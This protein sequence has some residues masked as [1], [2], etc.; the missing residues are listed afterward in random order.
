MIAGTL[1]VQMLA[2]IARLRQDMQE[3]K[4]TVSKAVGDINRV[5]GSIGMGIS[6]GVVAAGFAT[7]IR[8]A[9]D[10]AISQRKLDAIIRATGN[11]SG[12]TAD[13][14][15]RLADS[16]ARS[17]TFDDEAFRE[18]TATLLRFGNIGGANL[19]KV[20][21]LSA[22]YAALTGGDLVSSA[23]KMGRAL[24]NPAEGLSKLERHF[25]S[26]APEVEAAIKQQAKMGDT[27][28]ALSIAIEA[29]Q[30]KIGGAD[31]Q[32]NSGLTGSVKQLTKA[33]SELMEVGGQ[34]GNNSAVTGFL[35]GLSSRLRGLKTVLEGDWTM[36]LLAIMGG[37]KLLAALGNAKPE[38]VTPGAGG[39]P[40]DLGIV[41]EGLDARG[42]AMWKMRVE[43][44]EKAKK[45]AEEW[46]RHED[47]MRKLDL[48]GWVDLAKKLADPGGVFDQE[49][50]DIARLNQERFDAEE[51]IRKQ[52]LEGQMW[53]SKNVVKIVQ[54]EADQVEALRKA[55]V[56]AFL[57]ELSTAAGNFFS[58][59]MMNGRTAFDNLR[60]YLKQLLADMLALFAK[61]WVLN[62]AAGG[63]MLGSAGSAMAGGLG[64]AG[65]GSIAGGL[66]GS[67]GSILPSGSIGTAFGN[68][69][70]MGASFLG[71]GG[72]LASTIGSVA[73]F[74]PAI[75]TAVAVA[76]M[77]YNAFNDG[78]ENPNF[79]WMQ[80]VGGEG[81]FGGISTQGNYGYD[82]TGIGRY[83]G[84]L[85]TRFARILGPGG[86]AAA[87]AGLAA[88]TQ[89]GLR[90]DGQ[91]AQFAFPEGTDRE[92]AE[93]IAKEVLQSRYGIIFAQI[94]STIAETIRGFSGTSTELQTYIETALGVVE[95]LSGLG[96][97][98]LDVTTLQLMATE[99]EELGATFTRV[100]GQ[101]GQFNQLF[102]TEAEQLA[103]AQD[104]VTTTF[105]D[106]GIAIPAS[107]DEFEALVR[108]LDLSTESGR[109]LFTALM[110]V[111]PAF[112]AVED[113]AG[114]MMDSFYSLM[115]QMRGPQYSASVTQ[116]LLQQSVQQFMA[117][118]AWTQ[119]M[120]WQEV[121]AAFGTIT[122]EDFGAYSLANQQ[123]IL[124]ILGY[125]N[126][127]NQAG[128]ETSTYTSA[129][130]GA[131]TAVDT[132][133]NAIAQ[134]KLGIRDWLDKIFLDNVSPLTPAERLAFAEGNYAT[135]L[136]G[137]QASNASD[138]AKF[139]QFADAYL[140]EAAS[141]WATSSPEYRAIFEA[142]TGAGKGLSGLEDTGPV[143][144][145][146]ARENTE[147]I[148][149]ELRGIQTTIRDLGD[150][151]IA[152][153]RATEQV[154]DS[155][156]RLNRT[157][158]LV[159]QEQ[160]RVLASDLGV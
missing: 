133:A 92:A 118:N 87:T 132:F 156:D 16:L 91:P 75:G 58:D 28:G 70:N 138:L 153:N 82:A 33:F 3:A 120:G 126:Q 101:W 121:A 27:S 99:G 127:L 105:A 50:L 102:T 129:V 17:S 8:A 23:E 41:D 148:V 57:D 154:R 107:K 155:V 85:D 29:L 100:A 18:A 110:Q 113:A 104:L 124:E 72:S 37:Q 42:Q 96:I 65:D 74:L 78:P 25:G 69:A 125:Q 24:S 81:A 9:E 77:I 95:G 19:E 134:A 71:A 66:L 7:M 64:T 2:N 32:M 56:M 38:T 51:E 6:F 108:G 143:N 40:V 98:G 68:I 109:Q 128:Q 67:I 106:L 30:K 53:L 140:R 47:Q 48:A 147:S 59:L 145:R 159:V 15:S 55:S 44:F 49:N 35:D 12:Y 46:Q 5:L 122:A 115:A 112:A 160:T 151:T 142:V 139:T 114:S 123:L 36:K 141:Y 130:G 89:A 111:A 73:S 97:R 158:T 11:T 10:A 88:Y 4:N 152:L 157:Q 43:A 14:L 93:Q 20:L 146:D 26:L 60:R 22:D 144:R 76:A 90:S 135:T 83:I 84:G 116:G 86:T 13:Q 45:A 119:G 94:D 62:I 136:A 150:G 80:G 39:G 131:T 117:G 1:E 34:V 79:R 21:K 63:T 31:Q 61:R 54:D 149:L 52:D 137:A 103:A